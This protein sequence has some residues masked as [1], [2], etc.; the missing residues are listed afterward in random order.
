MGAGGILDMI[1][2]GKA[3]RSVAYYYLSQC[4]P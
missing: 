4:F 3:A 1:E 2:P